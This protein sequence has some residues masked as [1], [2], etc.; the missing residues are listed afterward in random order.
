MILVDTS[1]LLAFL[2]GE[3]IAAAE[4]LAA[5]LAVGEEIAL[6]PT[7]V[8]EALQGVRD[9]REWR[10]LRSY[11]ASQTMLDAV[12][13]LD[14]AIRAARIY[15]DCRRR[16]LTVRSATDCLI[17]EIALEHRVPLLQADRDFRTIARVRPLQLLP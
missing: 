10:R 5:T 15:L 13:P 3:E 12:E 7:V 14:T 8:Q 16:G 2:K 1:A 4:F 9:E 6:T 11:L 17:A